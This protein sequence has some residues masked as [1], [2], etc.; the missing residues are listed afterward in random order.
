M[1]GIVGTSLLLP[2]RFRSDDLG[3]WH[4]QL[5]CQMIGYQFRFCLENYLV[6]VSE[7]ALGVA[8]WYYAQAAKF[9]MQHW[10]LNDML[11]LFDLQIQLDSMQSTLS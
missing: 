5:I 4:T 6:Q 10:L 11:L 1:P 2:V 3:G 8:D 9:A 7:V